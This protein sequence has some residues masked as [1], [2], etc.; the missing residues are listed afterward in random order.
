MARLSSSTPSAAELSGLRAKKQGAIKATDLSFPLPDIEE[1]IDA[2]GRF[3]GDL[4]PGAAN[5]AA[6]AE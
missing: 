2:A 1:E 5:E 4:A 6:G 3:S